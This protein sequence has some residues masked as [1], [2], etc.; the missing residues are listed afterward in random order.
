LSEN[1]LKLTYEHLQG[2]WEGIG[3]GETEWVGQGK[4][5]EG[6]ERENGE[7]AWRGEVCVMG[8]KPLRVTILIP[9]SSSLLYV[10]H[11]AESV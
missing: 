9:I 4:R 1:A 7:G 5:G 10:G 11:V 3:K 8:S 6:R 2:A